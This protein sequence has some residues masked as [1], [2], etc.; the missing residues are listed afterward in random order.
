MGKRLIPRFHLVLLLI[1]FSQPL[2]AQTASP[3][4][5]ATAP[6]SSTDM[7][8]RM[9]KLEQQVADAKSS[10]DNGWMLTSSALVLMMTGPGLALFYGGL[11]RKKNVLGTM[12]QSFALMAVVTVLWGLFSFSLAFGSGNSFIGGLH[13]LFL[14]GVGAAPDPDYAGTIPL[15]TF[16]VYQLMFAIITPGLIA[17]AFAE[18]MKFSAMMVFMILWSIVVYDP[19]AHMVWGKGGLL[20]AALGGRFPTLDFAGGTV[21][22]ITS[23]VSALVCALYL[24][25]RVGYPKEPMPPHSVVLSFIG[26]CLLWVGWFGFNAGS[27][28]SAGSLATSAFV[29][30]HFAAAA[31]AAGWA[32]AEWFRNGKPSTLGAISGSVAGLVAITP[33]SGFVK[34][35]P[36]LLIGLIAGVFCYWMVAKVKAVFGYDDSLDAFGVHGAGGTLGA[37]LT[38][39]FAT[40]AV[41]PIFKDAQGN[42]LPSGLLEGNAH[43]LLNQFIGVAISWVIAIVGTLAILKFVDMT[44]GLRVTEEEEIQGLDLSQHGEEG[45]YW[46]ASA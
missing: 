30:T 44:I 8:A 31:A 22:H 20:N 21:V 32:G 43:Q 19:M 26:A 39:V 41:N 3:S 6:A 18:R 24:G 46:E 38:G 14:H 37:L 29:A 40:S 25:K 15:Q 9:A 33:A 13:H 17:G 45:Y 16:M 28:L 27:A 4:A 34:P 23:G 7:N 12:M 10:A 11:V 42:T 35:M 1:L 36:A 2:L 5:P